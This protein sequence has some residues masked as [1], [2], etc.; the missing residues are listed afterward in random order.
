MLLL[1]GCI[2]AR[3]SCWTMWLW[4]TIAITMLRTDCPLVVSVDENSATVGR[5]QPGEHPQS[6]TLK[7]KPEK[8][9]GHRELTVSD[10]PGSAVDRRWIV[11]E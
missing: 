3:R 2:L 5:L 9:A 11:P 7:P 10:A 1:E 6:S 4:K 8:P